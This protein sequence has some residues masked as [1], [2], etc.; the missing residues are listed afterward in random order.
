MPI[1]LDHLPLLADLQSAF[2][3]SIPEVDGEAK[4]PGCPGW[5]VRELVEHIAEVHHW[6]AAQARHEE[7]EP[8]SPSSDLVAHYEAC[9]RELRDT[10]ATLDPDAPARTLDGEGVV[11][12]WHR[13]QVHETLIHLHDLRAAAGNEVDEVAPDVWADTVD[14]VVTV[15]Y[16]RQVRLGRTPPVPHAVSLVAADADR[17]WQ[18]GDGEPGAVVTGPARKLALLLWRRTDVADEDLTVIGDRAGTIRTLASPI[19]P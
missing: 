2:H 19:T 13:R 10:L 14:E 7:M 4:I 12:F 16:P 17:V 9:A 8:L 6:A 18:L 3:R 5:T 11:S 1:V 15:M